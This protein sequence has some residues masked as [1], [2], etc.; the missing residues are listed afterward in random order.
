MMVTLFA[1][2]ASRFVSKEEEIVGLFAGVPRLGVH[3]STI[4]RLPTD[5]ACA[6]L[7]S[8]CDVVSKGLFSQLS[9]LVFVP[10]AGCG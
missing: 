3:I 7:C 9:P 8:P 2:I 6:F 5:I 1:W 10:V 4:L